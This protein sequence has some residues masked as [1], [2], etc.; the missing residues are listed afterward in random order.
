MICIQVSKAMY[1]LPDR[2]F[3]RI[4]VRSAHNVF[5]GSWGQ[6]SHHFSRLNV[7]VNPIL[8]DTW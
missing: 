2:P 3:S 6:L 8:G 4:S 1:S 5:R 7:G